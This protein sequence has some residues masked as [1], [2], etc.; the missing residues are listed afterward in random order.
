MQCRYHCRQC[1]G[2]KALDRRATSRRNSSKQGH[3]SPFI[4]AN[5]S[6]HVLDE[7]IGKGNLLTSGWLTARR[8][9]RFI[10]RTLDPNTEAR[11][12]S[13]SDGV[14]VKLSL[15]TF[16][17]ERKVQDMFIDCVFRHGVLCYDIDPLAGDLLPTIAPRSRM[18]AET[19]V[20]SI[21]TYCNSA[22]ISRGTG[23][24][25]L[26]RTLLLGPTVVANIAAGL[27]RLAY[28]VDIA[29]LRCLFDIS[30]D[31][32]KHAPTCFG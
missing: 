26:R 3:V 7:F 16:R 32:W 1:T 13:S 19:T 2:S 21:C 15:Q 5:F 20:P 28:C 12:W 6:H 11:D 24:Q 30:G 29:S 9:N 22:A 27:G 14:R 17:I 18:G 8:R 23:Y 31:L 10:S 4:C 25:S